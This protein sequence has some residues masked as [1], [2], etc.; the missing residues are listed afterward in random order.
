MQNDIK[1]LHL[2]NGEFYSGA[3]RVQ[4]LLGLCLPKL[5]FQV[6]FA[7]LKPDRFPKVRLSKNTTVYNLSMS[8]KFDLKSSKKLASLIKDIRCNLIHTHTPRACLIGRL[9][10]I[11]TRV[12][13]V[14]HI[15]SP[16]LFD[17]EIKLQNIVN[18]ITE[19]IS[20]IGVDGIIA[21][22]DSLKKYVI[23]QG[24][25]TKKVY[26]VRNGVPGVKKI[27]LRT[28]PKGTWTIGT[29]GLF[30]P[31]KGLDILLKAI[32]NLKSKEK[33]IFLV[34][35]GP[36]VS[37]EYENYIKRLTASLG[38]TEHV[39]WTGFVQH[40]DNELE[41]FNIFVL[42]SIFGEGLPMVM[43]EAMAAGLPVIVSRVEGMTEVIRHEREGLL[44]KP[45]SVREL[46]D[47][48]ERILN[49][50]IDWK[51][52]SINARMRHKKT[53]SDFAMA[54]GVAKV[55]RRILK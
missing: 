16:T 33:D 1:I 48:L 23:R 32:S 51:T 47:A 39:E 34:A 6:G 11:N 28:E 30:R 4:D 22:S 31:R 26:T 12:P 43:I 17:S 36:F 20:L 2:I 25:S 8:S 21:V 55:Y 46:T 37:T 24:I 52:M 53:F 38:I 15:H 9:A 45:G 40:V 13:M 54:Q 3:E 44:V 7:C 5:G 49:G 42:P 41:R 50:K 29:V 27:S 10:T 35:V 18:T 14:H 19:R